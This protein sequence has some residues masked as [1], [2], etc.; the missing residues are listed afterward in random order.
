MST[1]GKA[2]SKKSNESTAKVRVRVKMTMIGLFKKRQALAACLSL[3]N[4]ILLNAKDFRVKN[5]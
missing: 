3:Y 4:Y 2:K 1:T 5:Y